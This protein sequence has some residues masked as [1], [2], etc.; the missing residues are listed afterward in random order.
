MDYDAVIEEIKQSVVAVI[1]GAA[2]ELVDIELKRVPGGM[3]LVLF[4][5]RAEG[6]IT[7][8]ECARVNRAVGEMLD[9]KDIFAQPYTLEVSSPGIDRNLKTE[10]DF[11]SRVG[12]PVKFFLSQPVEG[13]IEWDGTVRTVDAT[14]VVIDARGRTLAVPLA[15][16]NKAHEIVQ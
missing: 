13:K 15:V 6:G 12:K 4:V 10:R 16:I 3:H 9:A 1:E 8:E 14:S 11:R 5:D 7:V 2:L